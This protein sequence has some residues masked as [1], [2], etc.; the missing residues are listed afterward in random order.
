MDLP[1]IW[2]TLVCIAASISMV[3]CTVSMQVAA[4]PAG[5][6]R[7]P[8][9]VVDQGPP[10]PTDPDAEPD[11]PYSPG[12]MMELGI[13]DVT[14]LEPM[15][16]ATYPSY[17]SSQIAKDDGGMWY[18]IATRAYL[19]KWVIVDGNYRYY[20]GGILQTGWKQ[21]PATN[22]AD[23]GVF[24]FYLGAD[25][26]M[27]TGWIYVSEDDVYYYLKPSTGIMAAA[28]WVKVNGYWYYFQADGGMEH[29][30]WFFM[31][32]VLYYLYPVQ[33]TTNGITYPEGSMAV[34]GHY[35]PR[36][37]EPTI[38]RNFYFAES[39]AKQV[40][41]YP[42]DSPT[43]RNVLLSRN[44]RYDG[45]HVANNHQGVDILS[46]TGTPVKNIVNGNI[47]Y[48]G[49]YDSTGNTVII[50]TSSNQLSP[51]LYVRYFHMQSYVSSLSRGQALSSRTLIGYVGN[52]GTDTTGPH[53]HLDVSATKDVNARGPLALTPENALN[54][55]A[56]FSLNEEDYT[57][58]NGYLFGPDMN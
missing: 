10:I 48:V 25:G 46:T 56:F 57:I 3:L 49:Y 51:T 53:L 31:K 6:G 27:R 35:L 47:E 8:I 19:N 20:D 17:T 9:T 44:I 11:A 55:L 39:G 40:W 33:T 22:E 24:W 37:D 2:K 4:S 52:T 43:G 50:S 23:A 21:L 54:P 15:V 58:Q 1:R 41:S 29:S 34:G 38:K 28:E 12:E 45:E 32:A 14:A 7:G 42:F 5:D 18:V 30:G 36:S 26:N 16:L 13:T